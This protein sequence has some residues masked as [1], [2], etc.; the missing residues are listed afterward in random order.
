MGTQSQ[1]RSPF[2]RVALVVLAI[3]FGIPLLMMLFAV[4]FM[5]MWAMGG[6]HMWDGAAGGPEFFVILLMLVPLLLLLLGVAYVARALFG[7]EGGATDPAMA[8][9]RRAYARGDL[10][11]EEFERRREQLRRD[12]E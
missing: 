2:L 9:L 4:P 11:D 7:D 3:V 5:G 1:E 8:E 12:E 6:G 10:T